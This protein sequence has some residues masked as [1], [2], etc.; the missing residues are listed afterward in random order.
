VCIAS[1]GMHHNALHH[2]A[3]LVKLLPPSSQ[4]KRGE[5]DVA[6]LCCVHSIALSVH[7]ILHWCPAAVS[8]KMLPASL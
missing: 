7:S 5:G 3:L 8:M 1:R 4:L 6:G 2:Y